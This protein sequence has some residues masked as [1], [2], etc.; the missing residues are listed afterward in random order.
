MPATE[1]DYNNAGV[2]Y[3][4]AGYF[5]VAWD[6]FKGALELHLA[7]EQ[8]RANPDV[9]LSKMSE[10]FIQRADTWYQR[11]VSSDLFEDAEEKFSPM[12]TSEHG[13]D[14]YFCHLF[15][16]R[17]PVEIPGDIPELDKSSFSGL[18]IILNLALL[19]HCRN[20]WSKQV[21]GLYKLAASLLSGKSSEAG[22]EIHIIN[23]AG[24]WYHQNGNVSV[25]EK[26][27]DRLA[28]ISR[29]VHLGSWVTPEVVGG[30]SFNLEWFANPRYK[31]SPAA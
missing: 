17:D 16:F 27:M 29:T 23:N 14:E 7:K 18:T 19:E 25:A 15:L 2:V 12:L 30:L 21:V 9:V 22:L 26:Y 1:Q 6:L 3:M 10:K 11:L 24:V 31:V 20:P 5:R 13:E 8:K 28:E 4:R